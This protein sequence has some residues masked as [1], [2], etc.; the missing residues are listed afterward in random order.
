MTVERFR[1]LGDDSKL[2]S[3]RAEL[4]QRKLRRQ[5]TVSGFKQ[6]QGEVLSVLVLLSGFVLL[7][8]YHAPLLFLYYLTKNTSFF[9]IHTVY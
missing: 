7:R 4:A 2:E 9:P 3:L 6:I 8:R 5:Q 1:S